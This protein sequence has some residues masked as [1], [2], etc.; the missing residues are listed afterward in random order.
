LSGDMAS[1]FKKFIKSSQKKNFE[2][3]VAKGNNWDYKV[4]CLIYD[5]NGR[6]V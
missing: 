2:A 6:K 4:H 1:T 5:Y 3:W